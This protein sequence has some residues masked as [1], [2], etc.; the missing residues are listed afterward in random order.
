MLK[1]NQKLNRMKA[2]AGAAFVVGMMAPHQAEAAAANKNFN[3]ISTN[4]IAGIESV[5]GLLIGVSYMMG[6]LFAILGCLKIKD[7]V[8]NP[9]QTALKDGVIRLAIG[10]ALL[11]LPIVLQAMQDLIND[12]NTTAIDANKVNKVKLQVN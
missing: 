4:I 11:A 3:D 12:G 8:E 2:M 6:L 5:P 10:G 9:S 1:L 7:H